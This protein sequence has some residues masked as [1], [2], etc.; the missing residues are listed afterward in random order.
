M[1]VVPKTSASNENAWFGLAKFAWSGY[2]H[3]QNLR[4]NELSSAKCHSSTIIW[5]KHLTN[6]RI[7]FLCPFSLRYVL[8]C[9]QCGVIYRSR[10]YWYGNELPDKNVVQTEIRH[11]WPGVSVH[12]GITTTNK[13]GVS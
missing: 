2:V 1:V 4:L 11:V 6:L 9:P 13:P 5:I 10:Q 3:S 8:E 7:S 12:D